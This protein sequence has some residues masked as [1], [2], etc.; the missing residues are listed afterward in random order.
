MFAFPA[1]ISQWD[2]HVVRLS[3][4]RPDKSPLSM[5]KAVP[6]LAGKATRRVLDSSVSF[7]GA[8]S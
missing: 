1:V 7:F 8:G 6:E 4:S 2:G 5:N 3:H